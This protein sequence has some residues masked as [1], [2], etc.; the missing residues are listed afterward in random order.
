MSTALAT[1]ETLIA[2]VSGENLQD[3]SGHPG[4]HQT[5]LKALAAVA[6][7]LSVD[8][9]LEKLLR[10]HPY[11][12]EP[13]A[14]ALASIATGEGL[15][16][17]S[18]TMNWDRL[19]RFDQLLPFLA[20]LSNGC[21]VVLVKLA[22]APGPQADAGVAIF[23]PRTSEAGVF[24]ISQQQF[25]AHW[26]GE[27]ILVKPAEERQIE[28]K[29]FD[30]SWFTSEFWRHKALVRNI[31]LA[32]L[33][34]HVLA[35]AV[36]IFFQTVIDRVLVYM[37]GATLTVITIGV[38]VAIVFDTVLSW[39]RG[40][41]ILRIASKID[42][43]LARRTFQHLMT[44][45]VSFFERIP[46]GVIAKHMQQ[47]SQIREFITGR[48]LMAILDLP[49]VLIFLPLMIWYSPLL[50]GLVVGATAI[51]GLTIAA[52]IGPYR[53]RLQRLYATEG[54]RQSLLVESIHGI[55]T[56]KSLNYT[57]RRGAIWE[58]AAARTVNNTLDVGNIALLAN[59]FSR[60]VEKL[61]TVGIIVVGSLLIFRNDMSVGALIA[62][63]ML[64]SRVISPVL[65]LVGLLNNYQ[66]TLLSVQM[67]GEIMNHAPETGS[68]RGLAPM[69]K[70]EIAF[71]QV[72]FRY[73]GSDRPALQ[74]ISLTIPAGAMVG[75]VGRSGSGK[76]TLSSLLQGLYS[77]SEG[78][79]RID[80]HDLRDLDLQFYRS[81][82][83][84]VPQDPFL[85]RGSVKENI[86]IG[87]GEASFEQVVEAARLAGAD[88]F[89]QRLPARYDTMLEE[90]ATNLS[91]GQR[92]RLAIAR[93]LLRDPRMI[94]FDEAT[95]ALDPESEA[96]VVRNLNEIARGRTTIII[97]HRLRT[98]KDADMIVV[99]DQGRISGVG[100]HQSLLEQ[101]ELYGQLWTQQ[102]GDA[103]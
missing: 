14:D 57:A 20:R 37:N 59:N 46:A 53:Q 28:K 98:I 44:L 9:S 30:L 95:S 74:N 96:I 78:A 86:R 76:T 41:F 15:K 39:L 66:E 84:V 61:L 60:L 48:L 70:G 64:S 102:I 18:V 73:P 19:S 90:G 7:H 69:L 93:A 4:G 26:N 2:G 91:G 31:A 101:N 58:D 52:L 33:V 50:T 72:T 34:M 42:I 43:R 45:P 47:G 92:Q 3:R 67:L 97:S 62:F 40:H 23:N 99:L 38:L 32:A 16:A 8:V 68:Q 54:Q 35:L 25:R 10:L 81:Q 89:V 71:D 1:S 83:G 22:T 82:L 77:S 85:F 94:L 100:S 36:P 56:I 65:Q 103:P 17:K 21:Y 5:G 6:R 11:D 75:I 13:D 29:N 79:V 80:G 27:I 24:R 12:Q 55:R 51:L 49:A 63:N 87:H 88:E